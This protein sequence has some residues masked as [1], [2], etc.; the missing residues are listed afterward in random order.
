MSR[1]QAQT[2]ARA[3]RQWLAA[4]SREVRGYLSLAIAAGVVGGLATLAQL[5]LMAWLISAVVVHESALVTLW[6]YAAALAGA[7]IVRSLAQWL[8]ETCG[9]EAGLRV[10]ARVR[11]QVLDHLAALGPVSLAER[12]SAGSTAQ[13]VDQVEALEGYIA[14]YVPQATLAVVMPLIFLGVAFSLDWLAALFFLI[15]APL[16]PLFMALI[17]MGAQR[18]NE[19]QFQAMTRL[20]GHFLDRVRGLTTLQL[21]GR[22]RQATEEV[23]A[24][25]DDYRRR[26]MKTLRVAFLSSAV[27][28]FFA[29]VSIAVIAIYIGFGLLGYI[30]FGPADQLTLFSGLFLLFM[31]PDFFQPLRLLAQHYHDRASALGA[32]E[33]LRAL[34]AQ[35]PPQGPRMAPLDSDD[36]TTP[37]RARLTEVSVTH[38]GRGRVLGPL[39][40]DIADGEVVALVGPSG[41]GK[42]TLLQVLAGFVDAES[43]EVLLH[44]ESRLAWLDQRPFLMQGTLAENL[45]LVAPEASDARLR[46]ALSAAQ[47]GD[48]LAALP[49]GLDTF[50]GE[51]GLGLSGGQASRLALARVFLSDA[52]LVL[53]DEPTASLDPDSERRV[54]EGLKQLAAQGRTLVIATHHPAVMAMAD[55]VL[56]LEAGQLHSQDVPTSPEAL[57]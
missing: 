31:A 30:Q 46:E 28:E 11:A 32:A 45:R 3:S 33:G 29:S 25:A 37:L 22:T 43:G 10:K 20:A 55:R 50:L 36:D 19:Q 57:S 6:P 23:T 44:A 42:S 40:L 34:L 49:E 35:T 1:S 15:A 26:N 47:L 38:T 21:F 39:D 2:P 9:L 18:L 51:R 13:L 8:Q 7:V 56:R 48:L 16:I 54:I 52:P 17:G 4:Q 41:A 24:V 5:G 27:L 12:H 53:L 14:R